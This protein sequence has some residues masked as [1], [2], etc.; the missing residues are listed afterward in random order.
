MIFLKHLWQFSRPHTI[1]GSICS[2]FCL[3]CVSTGKL[4]FNNHLQLLIT[5]LIVAICCNVFIVGLNQILDVQLDKINKPNLPLA[6]NNISMFTA[7]LIIG[8]SAFFSLLLAAFTSVELLLLIA[9]IMCIGILYSV[10]PIQLKKHHLPAAICITLVRGILVNIG[11]V[12][13]FNK[14]IYNSYQLPTILLPI[15]IFMVAFSIAIAWFKDLPDMNGDSKFQIKT[16]PIL[17]TSHIAITIGSGLVFSCYVFVMYWSFLYRYWGLI[18]IHLVA[19]VLFAINTFTV[20][21]TE[22]KT[23]K[24]FYMRFWVFFFAE[25]IFFTLWS[26]GII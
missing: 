9:I 22:P 7:K 14:Y 23:F 3:Y 26:L 12:I 13:H 4:L 19:I 18:L 20:N 21:V 16:F 8:I 5:T 15:T 24:P 1:I 2:I 25:Y 6:A 11:M 17:Y 10:P